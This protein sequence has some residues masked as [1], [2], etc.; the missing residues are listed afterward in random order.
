MSHRRASLARI[1]GLAAVSSIAVVMGTCTSACIDA[2]VFGVGE[3]GTNGAASTAGSRDGMVLVP[4]VVLSTGVAPATKPGED[5][6]PEDDSGKGKGKGKKDAGAPPP[7]PPGP[8]PG[9]DA[10]S[11]S[12][13]SS[14]G[15]SGGASTTSG[16]APSEPSDVVSVGAYWL[17][18]RE[19]TVA[20]FRRCVSAGACSD[21]PAAEGCTVHLGLDGHPATC[22]TLEQART[23]CRWQRK[24]LPSS[25]EW[26]AAA[27]GAAR[28]TYPWGDSA[29]ES[30]R[31]NACGSECLSQGMFA[32]SDGQ[33]ATAPVGSFPKGAS[34]EGALD[35]AGNVG[36]WVE[37]TADGVV[38]GGSFEDVDVAAVSST[39][40]REVG[41][42]A[43]L[44]SVGFRCAS[45]L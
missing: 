2:P 31:L 22:V 44:P 39:S 20:A 27:A 34:P 28:R 41:A 10:G 40:A 33:K 11:S 26:T 6:D 12:S 8:G 14:S 13:G 4:A 17:D 36:E 35:L 37:S 18:A 23:F 32:S 43:T 1:V 30:D 24:R 16:G 5:A 15:S 38:R 45:D 7:P 42:S 19:V 25:A 9:E 21:P 3:D 29:P